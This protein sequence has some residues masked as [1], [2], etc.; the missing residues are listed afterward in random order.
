MRPLL[1]KIQAFGS[2]RDL[3]AIDFT[4]P[5]QNLF[6]ITGDTGAG[7]TTIFDAM[8]F[9]LYGE[10]SSGANRKDGEELQSQY[11]E[12]SVEPCVEL[13]FREKGEIYTVS[14]SPRHSRPLKRKGQNETRVV[15]ET[16]SLTYPDGS[17]STQNVREVN[18]AIEELIGLNKD[19]F[20]Q[21]AMIA[22]GEFMDM[23]RAKS[24]DKKDVFRKLFR[25]EVYQS[26]VDEL[27]RRR[28]NI[29]GEMESQRNFIR[30]EAGHVVI[31]ESFR[32]SEELSELREDLTGSGMITDIKSAR[33][34]VMLEA[35]CLN[36]EKEKEAAQEAYDKAAAARDAKRDA[37]TGADNLEKF[38][39]QLDTAKRELEECEAL[40]QAMAQKRED[41]R[42]INAAYE[43]RSVWLRYDDSRQAAE[44]TAK[45]QTEL[46][47]EMPALAE[48]E[49]NLSQQEAQCR[50]TAEKERE[51]Y[52]KVWEKA[53][54]EKALVERL[55]GLSLEAEEKEKIA[56]TAKASEE[57]ARGDL[58]RLE[59]EEE[60]WK[61][62]EEKNRQ[63][64]ERLALWEVRGSEAERIGQD[65]SK[66]DDALHDLGEC[67]NEAKKAASAYH[68]IQE[69]AQAEA[70]KCVAA[71]G[72]YLDAQAGFLAQ[73]L[74]EG[75]PCPVCGSTTHPN[76]CE[77]HAGGEV[78]DR[79]TLDA[80]REKADRLKSEAANASNLS[81][82]AAARYHERR[83][84]LKESLKG[85]RA[86]L[87]LARGVSEESGAAGMPENEAEEK[88]LSIP[89][90]H[91]DL[92]HYREALDLEGDRLKKD[93]EALNK[94][95]E[96]LSAAAD[97]KKKI[98]D[99]IREAGEQSANAAAAQASINA[100][101]N[102]LKGERQYSSL[103]EADKEVKEAKERS[104][105]AEAAHTK[106]REAA[107]SAKTRKE[108]AEA[109]LRQ[110]EEDLPRLTGEA[111]ARKEEYREACL[112]N[113]CHQEPEKGWKKITDQ[114]PREE[115]ERLRKEIDA[116]AARKAA[117]QRMK[118]S[119]QEAIAD[120]KRPQTE[121][122]R[123]EAQA[124]EEALGGAA[125]ALES[126][127]RQYLADSEAL[128]KMGPLLAEYGKKQREYQQVN[129]LCN[130]LS[131]KVSGA[132]MDIETFVQ[133][134]YLEKI[135]RSANRRFLEMSAGQ[136]ELRM[137]DIEKAGE[138]KNRGLDL[139]VYSVVTGKEREVRTLSGGES[140][141]AALSLALGMAD[142]ISETTA[143][144]SPEIMFI[145]EGFGSLDDHARGQAVR[146]LQQ[147]AGG[148]KLI[149]IISHV[150]E[151]KNEIEDQLLVTK[152]DNGSHI[153][154]QIS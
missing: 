147:M 81:G 48:Q 125:A 78:P 42:R 76:P 96:W 108:K 71:T 65:L 27:D 61:Q 59:S 2:Y 110:C 152:D 124:A 32:D 13:T 107:L 20:M 123:Q 148:S 56:R 28:K 126:V 144:I 87:D 74:R 9:A 90:M 6:L 106:A 75:E 31:P 34:S 54:A 72:A 122:L 135:L 115:A 91:E 10:A 153:R 37:L 33:F 102:T 55:D 51:N 116:H 38:F 127:K 98:S 99:Q 130:R 100:Q 14:R 45:Q 140:F 154:W 8:V 40:E 151:L 137:Y 97:Q 150:T 141:M 69:K 12:L 70:S 89:K 138:G 25:T 134:Y 63:A 4:K 83:E 149:G 86:R 46:L 24:S 22:Q 82:E 23:L 111:D 139:M 16:V 41:V 5:D 1:L 3:T 19:Q 44:R 88:R 43:I 145:D 113:D 52:T 128:D 133:R 68:Q 79:E 17:V 136:F 49:K 92:D 85:I 80:M 105:N 29:Y 143:A 21:V 66:A 57:K 84:A 112:K 146:V 60:A 131:G 64:G 118:A 73:E 39:A 50:E 109:L 101:I 120:Q 77:L 103:E 142:Q 104:D 30:A 119:A 11:A 15:G 95:R 114:Y 7:K 36:L 53:K 94:A 67:L 132:H 117:A 18:A 93:A 26:M 129:S 58:S 47:K 62:V 121:I 35:L